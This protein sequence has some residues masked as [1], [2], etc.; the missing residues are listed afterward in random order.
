MVAGEDTGAPGVLAGEDT[1]A[2]G[3]AAGEDAGAP[4]AC[5]PAMIGR[6]VSSDDA[7]TKS[8]EG[9]PEDPDS[10]SGS[11]P[12]S[13]S[14]PDAGPASTTP[15]DTTRQRVERALARSVHRPRGREAARAARG[16]DFETFVAQQG[17]PIDRDAVRARV[18]E[19]LR[20][21]TRRPPPPWPPPAAAEESLAAPVEPAG[22]EGAVPPEPEPMEEAPGPGDGRKSG[23]SSRRSLDLPAE[24]PSRVAALAATCLYIGKLPLAPGT[25][26]AAAG[27]GAW[28]LSSGLPVASQWGLV[29][30]ASLLGI[31]ASGRYAGDRGAKDP[32]E[33]VV[34]EFC[35]MWLALVLAAHSLLSAGAL[36]VLFRL[37]DIAK[38]PPLRQL[39][40]VPGGFGIMLDDLLAGAIAGGAI[41]LAAWV[42]GPF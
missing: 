16:S 10:S 23:A 35:G 28:F 21:P 12:V 27:F 6:F 2:P 15:A 34:D 20:T 37:L 38:P 24:P 25:W 7:G 17:A 32:Q 13:P 14:S 11:E 3:A 42:F 30:A 5:W 4:G 26:G 33:V 31:W 22:T 29:G 8:P 1:G 36:F 19:R 41:A 9:F 18:E 40:R 39:E